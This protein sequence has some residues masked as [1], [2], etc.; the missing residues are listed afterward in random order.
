MQKKLLCL[1]QIKKCVFVGTPVSSIRHV[2]YP[3]QVKFNILSIISKIVFTE[4]S[5]VFI[6]V[7]FIYIYGN[8]SN[9]FKTDCILQA[10]SLYRSSGNVSEENKFQN[11]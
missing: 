4:W 3:C 6:I 10:R 9:M 2:S 8:H 7:V 1:K 11:H 5:V